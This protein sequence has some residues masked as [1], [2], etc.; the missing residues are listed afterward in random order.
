MLS[1]LGLAFLTGVHQY[2][3]CYP[4]QIS[5]IMFLLYHSAEMLPCHCTL[6]F[7]TA[8]C[9]ARAY[10]FQPFLCFPKLIQIKYILLHA[11]CN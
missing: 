8:H 6:P 9:N 4:C 11:G 5:P 1:V 10:P 3:F 2:Y 7:I